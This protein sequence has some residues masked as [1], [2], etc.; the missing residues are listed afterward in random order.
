MIVWTWGYE[1][2]YGI[3]EL[4]LLFLSIFLHENLEVFLSIS[5]LRLSLKNC[6][7]LSLGNSG[8]NHTLIAIIKHEIWSFCWNWSKL[9]R[10]YCTPKMNMNLTPN[11]K[12]A[13]NNTCKGLMSIPWTPRTPNLDLKWR[14]YGRLK[15]TKINC[16]E[17]KNREKWPKTRVT[18]TCNFE[19]ENDFKW[20]N[21]KNKNCSIL[22]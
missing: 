22:S 19:N 15:L 9:S 12:Y 8:T 20:K 21:E 3:F 16:P 11:E 5:R 18:F 17:N 4:K 2:R 10:F 13:S 1:Y 14:S 7:A 6:S